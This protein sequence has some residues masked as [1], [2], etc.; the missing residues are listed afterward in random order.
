[1]V[2]VDGRKFTLFT[3]KDGAWAADAK[4]D[5][6]LVKAMMKGRRMT[7]RGTSSRGTKTVDT[8]SLIGFTRAHQAIGKACKTR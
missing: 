7:I 4:A 6:A 2:E 1:M 3:H 8:Y 5:T